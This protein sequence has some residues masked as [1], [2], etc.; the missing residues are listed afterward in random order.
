MAGTPR[1][2]ANSNKKFHSGIGKTL[3]PK[4]KGNGLGVGPVVLGIF[5]F[6]VMGSALLQIF[7]TP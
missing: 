3:E 2:I 6:V 1:K 4:K 5:I 7:K